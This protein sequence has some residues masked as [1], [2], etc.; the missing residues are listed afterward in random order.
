MSLCFELLPQ[1]LSAFRPFANAHITCVHTISPFSRRGFGL[2]SEEKAL[3]ASKKRAREEKKKERQAEKKKKAEEAAEE[4][5]EDWDYCVCCDKQD[6][7]AQNNPNP[8]GCIAFPDGSMMEVWRCVSCGEI[9]RYP[10]APPVTVFSS[11][12]D[13]DDEEEEES[14]DEEE[15]ARTFLMN[16]AL[17]NGGPFAGAGW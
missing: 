9:P 8:A 17:L 10:N 6:F 13:D 12:D 11:D 1:L 3:K 14:A 2:T 5:S 15:R 16:Y 4:A 7:G